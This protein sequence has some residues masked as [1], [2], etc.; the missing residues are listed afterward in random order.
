MIT[1]LPTRIRL[2]SL[3]SRP[4]SRS[5]IR[6]THHIKSR[7]TAPRQLLLK[8]QHTRFYTPPPGSPPL[9]SPQNPANLQSILPENHPPPPPSPKRSLK[10]YIY[11]ATFFLLGTLLGQYTS[12]VLAPPPLPLPST[13]EDNLMVS[14]IQ[15]RASRLPIVQSLSND[16]AWTHHDAYT[17][18][19]EHERAKRLTTGPLAGARGIGGYQ[20]IFFNKESG[21]TVTV[22]WMGG[23]LAGW[24]GVTHGG[25]IATVMD[26]SLGRCAIRRFKEK[27]GVTANLELDYLKPV[28]TNSFYVV[29]ATPRVE[30]EAER[31]CWVT[32][33]LETLEGRVCVEAKALFVVPKRYRTREIGGQF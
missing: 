16:P 30:G 29:R 1:R 21:E 2:V 26:E 10:P 4:V 8:S 25:V 20:R 7:P 15:N 14:M 28:V 17:S 24:P 31:K 27:T 33:R 5:A 19:P 12:L 11:A 23:A 13:A 9:E 6:C 22:I 32:A 3:A 18:L